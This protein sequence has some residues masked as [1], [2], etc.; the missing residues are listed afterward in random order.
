M[1]GRAG[2]PETTSAATAPSPGTTS[3]GHAAADR[4]AHQPEARIGEAAACPRR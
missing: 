2:S 3:T 4:L 1:N